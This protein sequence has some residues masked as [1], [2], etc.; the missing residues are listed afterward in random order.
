MDKWVFEGVAEAFSNVL[1]IKVIS[2]HVVVV[3]KSPKKQAWLLDVM[4]E[5]CCVLTDVKVFSLPEG[6]LHECKRHTQHKCPVASG[7]IHYY[8]FSCKSASR[9][10]NAVPPDVKKSMLADDSSSTTTGDTYRCGI[11]YL[12][13]NKPAFVI[14]ENVDTLAD[15]ETSPDS[16]INTI[17]KDCVFCFCF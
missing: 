15:N 13:K 9:A 4:P 14:W 5:N 7:D 11:L 16:N 10:N 12:R 17:I 2:E 1:G 6:T 8:G 3:E